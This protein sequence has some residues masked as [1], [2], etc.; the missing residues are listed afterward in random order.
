MDKTTVPFVALTESTRPVPRRI[1][2]SAP[3]PDWC[4]G[5]H[6][7]LRQ[8][9][10][11]H[12]GVV[13]RFETRE[14]VEHTGIQVVAVT[15][16]CWDVLD[17]RGRA[18]RYAPRLDLTDEAGRTVA[19]WDT[20]EQAGQV[21][22]ML[23]AATAA[24]AEAQTPT[25]GLARVERDVANFATSDSTSDLVSAWLESMRARG[26]SQRTITG[27]EQLLAN[28]KQASGVAA[29]ALTAEQISE[30][31]ATLDIGRSSRATY[32][33]EL[34][35]WFGWLVKTGHRAD[36]PISRLDAPRAPKG[37]PR[38]VTSE[39]VRRLLDSGIRKDVAA[40]VLLACYAGLRVSE[41]AALNG[42]DVDLEN[43]LL[44]VTGKGG[45]TA[46]LPLHPRIADLA[47]TM[48]AGKWFVTGS[49][50]EAIGGRGVSSAISRAMQRAGIKGSAHQLRH[51][52]ASQLVEVG[53]DLR[54]VQTLMRHENLN[55]T[56]RYTAIDA[57][58]MQRAVSALTI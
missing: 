11:L 3:C 14:S 7:P 50:G 53:T 21:V 54:T 43:G 20:S 35:S 58:R 23:T 56:A 46:H 26:L 33:S 12:R 25:A 40:M 1:A 22:A 52:Y 4:D 32:F 31:L 28:I 27:R 48:P 34:S 57:K 47:A 15:L 42:Q 9:A 2:V 44:T 36:N 19:G 24:L 41:I 55:T 39:Q 29:S 51:W 49:G 6:V 30:W 5:E 8:G 45:K 18:L 37:Q 17:G 10:V 16:A 38:P 13:G